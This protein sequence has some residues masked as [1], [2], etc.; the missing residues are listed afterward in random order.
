MIDRFEIKLKRGSLTIKPSPDDQWHLQSEPELV[1]EVGL[2]GVI[3]NGES[4]SAPVQAT[5]LVPGPGEQLDAAVGRGPCQIEGVSFGTAEVSLGLGDLTLKDSQGDWEVNLGKGD[6]SLERFSGKLDINLGM[7]RLDLKQV[8]ATADIN[9][10][11][12]AIFGEQCDGAYDINAGKGD[13]RWNDG[14]GSAEMNA[15]LGTITVENGHGH[16]LSLKS[17]MGKVFVLNGSWHRAQ[18]ETGLG[19]VSV[20]SRITD[21]AVHVKQRGH[22]EVSLPDDVGARVE[23]S[24]DRGRIVSHLDLIPVGHAGPQRGQRLVGLIGD[25]SGTVELETRRGDIT[26]SLFP[27]SKGNRADEAPARPS[28]EDERLFILEQLQRGHLTIDQADA[29][30]EALDDATA[31]SQS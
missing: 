10:G 29:L 4:I 8:N 2:N 15:G 23:A 9:N 1:P 30:L 21:L 19:D 25:G 26:L 14:G 22:I 27:A 7:G 17:G 24:T 3:I 16:E 5:V 6:A 28:P 13:I 31:S 12:G 20:S 18:V 11:L